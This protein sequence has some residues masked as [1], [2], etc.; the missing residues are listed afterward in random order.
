MKSA[1]PPLNWSSGHVSLQTLLPS[2]LVFDALAS[3]H[4]FPGILVPREYYHA[5]LSRHSMQH[6]T[7]HIQ[8]NF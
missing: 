4:A 1:M 3:V 5:A 2:K 8:K 7:E 6:R